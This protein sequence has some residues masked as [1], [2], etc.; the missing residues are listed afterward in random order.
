MVTLLFNACAQQGTE[1]ALNVVRQA[2]EKM[3]VSF[4]S[5]HRLVTSLLDALIKSGDLPGAERVFPNMNRSAVSYGNMMCGYKRSK[6]PMKT[7][8]LLDR[9]AKESI[10]PNSCLK[11]PAKSSPFNALILPTPCLVQL[12]PP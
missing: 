8:Q 1:E 9:M 12:S 7:L 5:N 6:Q 11:S 2:S 4:R 3:P 10:E